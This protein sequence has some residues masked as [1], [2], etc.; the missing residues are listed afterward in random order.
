MVTRHRYLYFNSNAPMAGAIQGMAHV[1]SNDPDTQTCI[2]Q[3]DPPNRGARRKA[4]PLHGEERNLARR[5][6]G[7][8]GRAYS[9]VRWGAYRHQ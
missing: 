9:V 5:A 7:T 6:S 1:T 2:D 3:F 4:P 8:R